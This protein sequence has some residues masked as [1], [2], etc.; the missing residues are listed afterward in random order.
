MPSRST[1]L[2][3]LLVVVIVT[4]GC[5][6]GPAPGTEPT[7]DETP[8]A[9]ATPTP[10]A[11][12]TPP[13]KTP[14]YTPPGTEYASEQPDASHSI[15]VEN[16]WNQSVRINVTVVREATNETV[17]EGSYD[18]AAGG[19]QAIYDTA[20]ADPDGIERFTVEATALNATESVTIETSKCHGN[21]YVEI[22][23]D[24]ELYP[25]YAIC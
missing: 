8:T 19:E 11:S 23:A 12:P 1:P 21:V 10:T 15:T 16:E 4:A 9:T 5:L 13:D 22:T 2:M 18:V 24:G 7:T 6:G 17:H 3:A 25:Y 14:T 20:E